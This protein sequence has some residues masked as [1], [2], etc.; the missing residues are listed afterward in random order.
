M[1]HSAFVALTFPDLL[2]K[3]LVCQPQDKM[4]LFWGEGGGAVGVSFFN[5]L[6]KRIVG[7]DSGL[8]AS[9]PWAQKGNDWFFLFIYFFPF[10]S[11]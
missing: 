1:P 2:S 7:D 3:H 10:F 5:K 8:Q 9:R 6:K 4:L 11:R